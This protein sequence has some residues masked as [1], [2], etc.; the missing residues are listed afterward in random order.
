MAKFVNPGKVYD[1]QKFLEED[2]P[3]IK[4][5]NK[6]GAKD[7]REYKKMQKKKAT[8][9]TC[10]GCTS[11]ATCKAQNRCRVSGRSL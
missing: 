4:Q 1:E 6:A 5:L 7:P 2:I 8:K 9:K 3:T 11:P 10:P